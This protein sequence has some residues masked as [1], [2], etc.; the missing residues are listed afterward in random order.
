MNDNSV[1]SDD[2][3]INSQYYS[4]KSV[5]QLVVVL[6]NNDPFD[7]YHNSYSFPVYKTDKVRRDPIW[8]DEGD[9]GIVLEETHVMLRIIFS[10]DKV[11]AWIDRLYVK[12]L[13]GDL[14]ESGGWS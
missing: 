3:K 11:T 1:Y 2:T 7:L 10:R 8:V 13:T 5:G 14:K 9:V 12:G 6:M 4:V